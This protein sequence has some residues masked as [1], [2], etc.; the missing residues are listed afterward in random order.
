MC[1][2]KWSKEN[3]PGPHKTKIRFLHVHLYVNILQIYCEINEVIKRLYSY[4]EFSAN[5]FL[6]KSESWLCKF[7]RQNNIAMQA[8]LA[9]FTHQKLEKQE[10][11]VHKTACEYKIRSGRQEVRI[12]HSLTSIVGGNIALKSA[13]NMVNKNTGPIKRHVIR[14]PGVGLKG[15]KVAELPQHRNYKLSIKRA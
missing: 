9:V 13:S 2:L 14:R 1:K 3:P 8:D 11:T 6:C 12:T 15:V 5:F 10:Q 7:D 4:N